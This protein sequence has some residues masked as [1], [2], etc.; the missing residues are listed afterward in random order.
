MSTPITQASFGTGSF[1]TPSTQGGPAFSMSN[2]S[3]L[4]LQTFLAD[5]TKLPS[6][7]AQLAANMGS[8]APSP[9]T[10]FDKLITL[11]VSMQSQGS[12]FTNTLYP[13]IVSLA[14]DIYNYATS[15][16]GYYQGL[17]EEINALNTK[18]ITPA[19]QQQCQQN[20]IAIVNQLAT[21]IAPYISNAN[22]VVSNLKSFVSNLQSDSNTL[23][24]YYTYYNNEYGTN[25]QAK[26]DLIT[27]LATENAAL[28]TARSDYNYDVTVAATTPTYGW[29]LFAGTIAAVVVAGVYGARATA[30]LNTIHSIE[31][32][33]SSLQAQEQADINMMASLN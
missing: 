24:N 16:N 20:I 21:N 4:S 9:M 23:G 8:G 13:S 29:I 32:T 25:S 2:Q 31:A 22:A 26:K 11:Y 10:D 5:V 19:Q 27:Q 1:S 17:Q 15:I 6:T 3:W 7:T 30:A 33:I 28:Q 14:S 18:G 12:G